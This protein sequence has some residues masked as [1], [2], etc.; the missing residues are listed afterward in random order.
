M[1]LEEL[2]VAGSYAGAQSSPWLSLWLTRQGSIYACAVIIC[3][4]PTH[5]HGKSKSAAGL[6]ESMNVG[7]SHRMW[8]AWQI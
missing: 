1:E 3:L 2:E 7:Q 6:W 8:D 5:N 4:M